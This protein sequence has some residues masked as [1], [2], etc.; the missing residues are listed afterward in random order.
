MDGAISGLSTVAPELF[1][2]FVKVGRGDLEEA[3]E[4]HRCVLPL[5]IFY[6]FLE[7]QTGPVFETAGFP[8]IQR[9]A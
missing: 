7:G 5:T 9:K 1:T 2:S 8:P 3:A 6:T 4:P